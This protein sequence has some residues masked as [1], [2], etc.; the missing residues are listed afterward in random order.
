MNIRFHTAALTF[1]P[2]APYVTTH[3]TSQKIWRPCLYAAAATAICATRPALRTACLALAPGAACDWLLPLHRP[4]GPLH[5]QPGPGTTRPPPTGPTRPPP[6]SP[7]WPCPALSAQPQCYLPHAVLTI[8]VPAPVPP[9][10]RWP[11]LLRGWRVA[12]DLSPSLAL[13]PSRPRSCGCEFF[14]VF[15]N[16]TSNVSKLWWNL[17]MLD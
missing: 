13:D 14:W 1:P 11:L 2:R 10:P 5:R 4:H 6:I 17:F 3:F 12:P 15:I 16:F 8:G 7:S 9:A